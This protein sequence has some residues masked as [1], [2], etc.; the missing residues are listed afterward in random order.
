MSAVNRRHNSELVAAILNDMRRISMFLGHFLAFYLLVFANS[1]DAAMLYMDPP[2]SEINRG[3]SVMVSVRLDTDE[4]AG[5]CIN[6]V[7]AVITYPVNIAP[8][9]ISL[10]ESIFSIWVEEPKINAEERTI[11]LAGGI[12]NGYCGRVQGDPSL[13]NKL[14]NIVFRSPGFTVGGGSA[15]EN[16]AEINF[17]PETTAYLNDGQGSQANLVAYGAKILLNKSGGSS[18]I[19]PWKEEVDGDSIPPEQ[20][21]ITLEKDRVAFGGKYYIAFNTQDKQTGI[22]HYEIMEEPL[23]DFGSFVWGG[24]DMPWITA[25]SPYVLEDQSLNSTIRVKAIDKAGNEYVA[26]LIPEDS[27]RTLSKADMFKFLMIGAIG[28]LIVTILVGV[29]A[30]IRIIRRKKK[31]KNEAEKINDNNVPHDSQI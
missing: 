1:A 10:G 24:A 28:F 17:A 19:N 22:D 26:T 5:E 2:Q 12:P 21:S 8:V 29:S 7:D 15:D 13:T 23:S 20:F 18:I 14:L 6:A 31:A 11:T 3:D 25:R 30:I 27:I 9:D 4:A 16:V